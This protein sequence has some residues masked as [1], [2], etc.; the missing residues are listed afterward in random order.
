MKLHELTAPVRKTKRRVGR[1]LS[2]GQGKTAGRGTKG[3]RARTGF[4]LPRRFE[5]GQSPFIMRLP[6]KRG[7]RSVHKKAVTVQINQVLIAIPKGRITPGA[8]LKAGLIN[9]QEKHHGLFKLVGKTEQLRAL[10]WSKQIK[11][12]KK[13]LNELAKITPQKTALDV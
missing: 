9:K 6:K 4:K 1:G 3:Q 11:L 5:G 13:L 8:L 12:T 7:F 10:N 2:A